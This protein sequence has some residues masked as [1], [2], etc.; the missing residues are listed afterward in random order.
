MNLPTQRRIRHGPRHREIH[1]DP[2]TNARRNQHAYAASPEREIEVQSRTV[3]YAAPR[4]H[5]ATT[6]GPREPG[7]VDA[8]GGKGQQAIAILQT[9]RRAAGC[10]VRVR[11]LD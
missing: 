6:H 11:D 5:F 3:D 1:P 7:D 4:A 9:D 10:D 8:T 2:S